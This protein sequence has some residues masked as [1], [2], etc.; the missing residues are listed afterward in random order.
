MVAKVCCLIVVVAFLS[1]GVHAENITVG[2]AADTWV[3][4]NDTTVHGS[5]VYVY[6]SDTTNGTGYLRFDLS[7]YHIL[8]VQSATL[9]LRSSGGA[10][11]NDNVVA[12]RFILNGLNDIAGNTPQGWDEAQLT[13]A[14][15]GAEWTTGAGV[16]LTNVTV[17]DDVTAGITETITRVGAA[18]GDPGAMSIVVTG[19]PLV[20]FIQNRVRDNGLVTFVL[21]FPGTTGRGYGIAS[22]ENTTA[23]WRPVLELAVVTGSKATAYK[24]SPADKATDVD[25]TA[26]LGWTAGYSSSS[27]DVY[28]GTVLNDV[29]TASTTD[30]H[31]VFAGHQAADVN[32]FAPAG[33]AFGEAYYWRVDEV[34]GSDSTVQKGQIWS[35]TV[36]PYAYPVKPIAATAS[37]SLNSTMGPDKT[38]D[39]SGLNASDQHSTMDSQMW[40]TS[41]ASPLPAWIQYKLD[42]AYKLHEMWVWNSNQGIEVAIG[43]GAKDVV[44]ET[45]LDGVTWSAVAGVPEFEQATG[46]ADYPHNTTV[47][48]GGAVAQYVKLTIKETWGSTKQTGLSEVRFFQVPVWARE[49]QPASG[50]TGIVPG[51]GLKWRPGREAANHKVYLG[52]D[53]NS[54]ALAAT[55]QTSSYVPADVILGTQYT[56]RIDEVNAAEAVS[57]WPG[58]V[59][60]FSTPDSLVVDD[61]ESYNDTC[62]RVFF[63]W[64]DG[65]GH[66]GSKDCGVAASQGNASGSTVGN[67]NPPFAEQTIVHA[68]R[69]SMPFGYD[70]TT[71]KTSEATRTFDVAQNWTASGIKTLVLFFRGDPANTTGQLFVK[72]N[73][74]RVNYPGG[75]E[76]QKSLLWKQWNIDLAGIAGLNAVKT[77]TV[78]VADSGKGTLYIDD[79]RLYR[80]APAVVQPADPGTSGLV[81]QYSMEGDARDSRGGHNGVAT[82]V[83][84]PNSL[85][86]YGTAAQFGGVTSFI[87]L[88]ESFGNVVAS[89]GSSTFSV[90]MYNNGATTTAWQRLFDFGMGG[91]TPTVYV[92]MTGRSTTNNAPRFAYRIASSTAET[93]ATGSRALTVGWHH[94]AAVVDAS[95]MTVSLYVD[96]VLAQGNVSTTILPKD[97]GKTTQNWLGRSQFTADPFLNGAIDEFRIYNRALS[98]GEVRYLGGDR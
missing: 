85:A 16:A 76:V 59:W 12:A 49:P 80:S 95:T 68:G 13:S 86:G 90:W 30:P 73:G 96:G 72:I 40:L 18:Y 37:S 91:T 15:V 65:F 20:Q 29:N 69:Q 33:L 10:P 19:D 89:L 28:L 81:A 27:H 2:P 11:R 25:R 36:E 1:A 44:V 38:I 5:D 24:P 3:R 7:S 51:T 58:D 67:L 6:L 60:T 45:S 47:S 39:G 88:G 54:L 79:I 83:T 8:T 61:F 50:A 9:R 77:L 34:N 23:E 75:A 66:N 84:Y 4:S 64:I 94:L 22:R 87:D 82:E 31:G 42:K 71:A 74:N 26:V 92:F 17:L 57:T 35:F 32:T 21:K 14:N 97:L 62:N 53:P 63:N 78:G 55:T 46:S 41:A 70:N 98:A 56:W 52:A 93:M 48:L 43:F